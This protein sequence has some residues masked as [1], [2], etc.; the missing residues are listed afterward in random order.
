MAPGHGQYLN[1]LSPET[2]ASASG[3]S[4]TTR[5]SVAIMART[6][7]P[8][9]LAASL[10]VVGAVP[11]NIPS[12]SEAQTQ[13]EALTVAEAGSGDDYDRDLFPHWIS[14]GN[15]CDTRDVVLI[16]D[17]SDV[18][19]GSG[20]SIESGT[21][22]SEYDGED[23]TETGDVDI[24]H[25]VP[26]ANAWRSGA[27]EWTTDE[28]QAFANDLDNPQLLAVT[29]NVNQE[30]GDAGPEEWLPPLDSYYCT[31]GKMWT[32][33]KYTYGLTV[34]DAEKSAL[35]DLLATC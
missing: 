14:Q 21:W 7:I 22:H 25:V 16:R 20:C 4:K 15:S 19:T 18:E 27:S 28:R 8:V 17:G 29:D 24:D 11:P 34:T 26:L 2:V 5:N 32:A 9:L 30:K 13:L 10:Q 3:V 1:S 12:T 6:L 23:W 33:I 31:Y 35:E